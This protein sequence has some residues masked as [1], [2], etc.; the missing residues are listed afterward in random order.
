MP[1]VTKLVSFRLSAEAFEQLTALG[2]RTGM[3]AG[4]VA[5]E[6]VLAKLTEAA[7]TRD[8]GEELW[9]EVRTLRAELAVATEAVLLVLAPHEEAQKKASAWVRTKLNR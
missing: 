4:G 1:R 9:K 2:E 6:A 5:R 3:S 7:T 8:R